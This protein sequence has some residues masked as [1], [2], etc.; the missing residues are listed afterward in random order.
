MWNLGGFA[1]QAI[2]VFFLTPY[3]LHNLGDI[4]YGLWILAVS[5]TGHY[6]LLSFGIR[7]GLAQYLTRYLSSRDYQRMND[8]AST[9]LVILSLVGLAVVGVATTI[10]LTLPKWVKIPAGL[11][12]DIVW[13]LLIIG[14]AAGLQMPFHVYEAVYPAAQ[15]FDITN[16]VAIATRL[17][18]AGFIFASISLGYGLIGLSL[19]IVI[20]DFL[21]HILRW[22]LAYRVIPELKISL[23]FFNKSRRNEMM[24]YG[25]WSFVISIAASIFIGSDAIVI[26]ATM[27]IAAVAFYSLAAG[28]VDQLEGALRRIDRVFFPL[29]TAL[30]AEG[31]SELLREMY[32]T[33]SRMT[34][35]AMTI[36]AIPT[37][38]WAAD[39]YRLW[40]GEKY[41]QGGEF[42]SVAVVFHILLAAM[43]CRLL[44]VVGGQTLQAI[45]RVKPLAILAIIE[46]AANLVISIILVFHYGLIG[47]AVGTLISVVLFRTAAIPLLIGSELGVSLR[48][49]FAACLYR[50][51]LVSVAL[52]L[53]LVLFKTN[54]SPAQSFFGLALNGIFAALAGVA[55]AVVFGL[56]RDERQRYVFTPLRKV[57]VFLS[58]GAKGQD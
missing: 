30:D 14:V 18:S 3:V 11:T 4:R 53:L 19:S 5:V 20:T 34:L 43:A 8:A 35:I 32:L 33:G 23:R 21:G 54:I 39:F 24:S 46:A 50:P 41:V 37:G 57:R 48:T 7:G 1:V 45:R 58:D 13:S 42:T 16:I 36:V 44:P 12:D 22:K 2:V 28:L 49:Y 29:A 15:R 27:P 31:E 52:G 47:V 55:V 6:G 17:V 51:L 10:A 25:A 40:V 38:L 56:R 9:A 26:S